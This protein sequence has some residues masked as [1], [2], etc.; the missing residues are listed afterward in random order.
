MASRATTTT[1]AAAA[2]AAR[3]SD[4]ENTLVAHATEAYADEEM[5]VLP[6]SA[7]PLHVLRMGWNA[8]DQR[9][10]VSEALVRVEGAA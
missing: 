6:R 7:I 2:A 3:A 1:A 5:A 8:V 4:E 10:A 9:R